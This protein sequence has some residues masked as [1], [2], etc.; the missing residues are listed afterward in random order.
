MLRKL[1]KLRLLFFLIPCIALF[2][3]TY[4]FIFKDLPSPY[5]LKN[6]KSTALST[7]IYD[8]EGRLLYEIYR[9]ENGTPV[10]LGELP[11]YV[12][13]ASI[14]IEDKDFFKHQGVSV[15]SGVLRAAKEIVV[16]HSLQ[17]GST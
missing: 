13:E 1:W 5:D 7:H 17:G 15:F 6:F 2:V 16:N 14:A 4:F 10:K 9:D 8:R 12:S 3:A 11:G